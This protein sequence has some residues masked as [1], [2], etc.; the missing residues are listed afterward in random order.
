MFDRK[1]S[2]ARNRPGTPTSASTQGRII[3]EVRYCRKGAM[4][5]DTVRNRLRT[6][7]RVDWTR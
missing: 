3:T 5:P 2:S 6:R 7:D 4:L 1:A